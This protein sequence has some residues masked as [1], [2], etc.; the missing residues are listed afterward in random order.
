MDERFTSVGQAIAAYKKLNATMQ[1]ARRLYWGHES[2]LVVESFVHEFDDKGGFL[3]H[4]QR[5]RW[6]FGGWYSVCKHLLFDINLQQCNMRTIS[7]QQ[8]GQS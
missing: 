5:Q 4:T 3:E 1:Q 8:P 2:R 7:T 6:T